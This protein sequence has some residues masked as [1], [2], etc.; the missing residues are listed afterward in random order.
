MTSKKTGFYDNGFLTKAGKKEFEKRAK[1]VKTAITDLKL[2]VGD[3]FCAG[4]YEALEKMTDQV[5]E[6]HS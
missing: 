5:K 4:L 3:Y 1:A 6:Y 2:I